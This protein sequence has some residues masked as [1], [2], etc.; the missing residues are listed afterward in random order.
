MDC[1]EYLE[2]LSMDMYLKKISEAGFHIKHLI[3]NDFFT[4]SRLCVTDREK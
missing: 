2:S 1:I 4:L 3:F